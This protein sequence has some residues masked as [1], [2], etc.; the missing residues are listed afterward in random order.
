MVSVAKLDLNSLLNRCF[1]TCCLGDENSSKKKEALKLLQ[2]L[3]SDRD[4]DSAEIKEIIQSAKE[5]C[6]DPACSKIFSNLFSN[7]QLR[8][9]YQSL[10]LNGFKSIIDLAVEGVQYKNIQQSLSKYK[11]NQDQIQKLK[12][13]NNITEAQ[14]QIHPC[15][16]MMGS[17]KLFLLIQKDPI[18]DLDS[19]FN[20]SNL[21]EVIGKYERIIQMQKEYL[22]EEKRPESEKHL[23]KRALEINE[24]EF[25]ALNSAQNEIDFKTAHQIVTSTA[26][27][28][29]TN[30]IGLD[31][32]ISPLV[33]ANVFRI[34]QI[35]STQKIQVNLTFWQKLL[36]LLKAIKIMISAT[37]RGELNQIASFST[38]FMLSGIDSISSSRVQIGAYLMTPLGK[39]YY[40]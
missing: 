7:D 15:Y 9:Q 31:K 28:G 18:A 1:V 20:Y 13:V 40:K 2:R 30:D 33:A 37:F 27:R 10:T 26:K 6:S 14:A 24:K 29:E 8:E 23:V 3:D 39:K 19:G 11:L 36:T 21:H 38:L 4:K 32:D 22:Q 17:Y 34:Q 25:K 35:V 5:I 16:H 12:S